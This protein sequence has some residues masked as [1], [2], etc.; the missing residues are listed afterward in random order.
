[1]LMGDRD[2]L[3]NVRN[4]YSVDRA[5]GSRTGSTDKHACSVKR[6]MIDLM[7]VV[8]RRGQGV[9]GLWQ[10]GGLG[11]ALRDALVRLGKLTRYERRSILAAGDYLILILVP[12]DDPFP[13]AQGTLLAAD[14]AP[15]WPVW[16]G[17]VAI[18]ANFRLRVYRRVTRSFGRRGVWLILVATSGPCCCFSPP[19]PISRASSACLAALFSFIRSSARL[20]CGAAERSSR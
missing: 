2:A 18:A 16:R 11:T 3:S 15:F 6:A 10:Q 9:L 5:A 17:A 19:S 7:A 12:L 4:V 14:L 8:H 13:A 1:M 20:R